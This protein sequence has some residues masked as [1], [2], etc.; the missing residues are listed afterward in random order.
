MWQ[1]EL[2]QIH[3]KS[4][5]ETDMLH[6]TKQRVNYIDRIYLN[7]SPKETAITTFQVKYQAHQT[8]HLDTITPQLTM[9]KKTSTFR[10]RSSVIT[11]ISV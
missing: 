1:C 4:Q 3:L 5:D 11:M 9:I 2:F 8:T 7:L 6:V 10:D